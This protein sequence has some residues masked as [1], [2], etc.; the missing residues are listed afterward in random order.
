MGENT[1]THQMRVGIFIVIGLTGLIFSI[2]FLGGDKRLFAKYVTLFGRMPHAQGLN[3]GSL[4]SLSGIGIGNVKDITFSPD[5]GVVV[6]M[7]INADYLPQLK[8]GS[9]LETRTQGALGDK[10]VY[11]QPGPETDHLGDGDTI[12]ASKAQDLMGVLSERGGEAAKI[13]EAVNETLKLLRSLNSGNRI[14]SIMANLKDASVDFK[15]MSSEGKSL[16]AELHSKDTGMAQTMKR[17]NSIVTKIDK[18]EGTLGA[19]INDSSVHDQIKKLLGA[20]GKKQYLQ[21]IIQSSID[22][23]G[24]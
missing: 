18:G 15:A 16:M 13:F 11:I 6:A 21:S 20:G 8:K 12:E 22:E 14:E 17:M 7:K 24:K 10:Y 5:G 4:V 2:F 1:R 19:L 3:Q 9:T 23:K